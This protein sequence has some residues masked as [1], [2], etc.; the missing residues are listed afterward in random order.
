GFWAIEQVDQEDLYCFGIT[1]VLYAGRTPFQRVEIVNTM[2]YGV[3]LLL[4]GRM[5]SAEDD[6]Y[7]YHEALVHPGMLA[8]ARPERVLIIGGG[9]GATLREV[10]AYR[11]VHRATTVDIDPEAVAVCRKYL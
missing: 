2:S 10:L 4:D 6:E 11:S 1:D 7:V 3:A 5:Q 9:E 8:H